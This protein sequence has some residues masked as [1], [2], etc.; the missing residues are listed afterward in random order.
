MIACGRVSDRTCLLV[1][2][3]DIMADGANIRCAL[4]TYLE[5][6]GQLVEQP[7]DHNFS[8]RVQNLLEV[9]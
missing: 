4:T 3:E 1:G 5:L 6:G 8:V 7:V 2:L 9:L